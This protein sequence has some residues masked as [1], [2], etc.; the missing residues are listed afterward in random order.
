[1][2][3]LPH[4]GFKRRRKTFLLTRLRCSLLCVCMQWLTRSER[5]FTSVAG[6]Q[7]ASFTRGH[8]VRV[9][10]FCLTMHVACFRGT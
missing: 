1:M 6:R 8:A 5:S 9:K 7:I 2:N 10:S 3:V 4:G